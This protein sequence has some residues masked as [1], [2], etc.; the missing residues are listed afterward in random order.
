VSV[1]LC[2]LHSALQAARRAGPSAISDNIVKFLPLVLDVTI[3]K[4]SDIIRTHKFTD[5]YINITGICK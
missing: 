3:S 4:Y 1:H 2:I 5:K